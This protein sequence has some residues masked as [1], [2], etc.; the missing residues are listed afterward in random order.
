MGRKERST[1]DLYEYL[2]QVGHALNLVCELPEW[3][4][5]AP[6]VKH[7]AHAAAESFAMNCRVLVEFL[8]ST[9]TYDEDIRATDYCGEGWSPGEA[10]VELKWMG[11]KHVA[12]MTAARIA[13]P[14]VIVT[15]DERCE[16][17]ARLL[18]TAEQFAAAIEDSS[19]AKRMAGFVT[20]ARALTSWPPPP[21]ASEDPGPFIKAIDR[22]APRR[23]PD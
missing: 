23:R 12:H 2:I 3:L 7:L 15:Y 1:E 9:A 6:L 20:H 5:R 4:E 22:L 18:N 8:W 16:I 10:L 21:T 14:L 13:D 17:R 19:S 11:D